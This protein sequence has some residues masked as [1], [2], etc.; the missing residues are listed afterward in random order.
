[1]SL[2]WDSS[3]AKHLKDPAGKWKLSHTKLLVM[4]KLADHASEDGMCWPSQVKIAEACGISRQWVNRIIK[5]LADDGTITMVRKSRSNWMTLHF[6]NLPD[7]SMEVQK[8]AEHSDDVNS[9]DISLDATEL[10]RNGDSDVNCEPSDVN[11]LV[12]TNHQ[13]RTI[14]EDSVPNGTGNFV[15]PTLSI[16]PPPVKKSDHQ[17]CVD[18]YFELYED[19]P[20]RGRQ[21]GALKEMLDAGHTPESII[22][23][24]RRQFMD[25]AGKR[26]ACFTGVQKALVRPKAF[27][28]PLQPASPNGQ[29]LPAATVRFKMPELA[30]LPLRQTNGGAR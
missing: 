3:Y 30:D 1:M 21:F 4:L 8:I 24:L 20:D 27:I 16:P 2:V 18:A 17:S 23:E 19:L 22:A 29:I 25:F 12:D 5:V 10:N 13:L 9:V 15:A 6:K 14:I 28:P 7:I 26:R 11:Q